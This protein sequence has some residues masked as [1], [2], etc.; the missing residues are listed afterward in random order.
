M[1]ISSEMFDRIN[2]GID[3]VSENKRRR[4]DDLYKAAQIREAGYQLT[5]DGG[6]MEDST[7]S[8]TKQIERQLKALQMDKILN[9]DK[10]SSSLDKAKEAKYLAEASQ[11]GQPKQLTPLQETQMK[12]NQDKLRASEEARLNKEEGLRTSAEDMLRTIETVK[13]GKK[14]FGPMGEVPSIVAP[15][16]ILSAGKDYGNRAEW[17]ANINNLLSKKVLDIMNEMK[18][19]S[20]TGATGFGQLNRSELQLLKDSSTALNKKL[21]PEIAEKYLNQIEGLYQRVLK[22]KGNQISSNSPEQNDDPMGVL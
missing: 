22:G 12:L 11:K 8:S 9:P 20:K 21:P 17:E 18:R 4:L 15:S 19:A 16:T 7:G 2:K 1:S 10:Y 13:K 6:L 14:Y 3:S 5:P